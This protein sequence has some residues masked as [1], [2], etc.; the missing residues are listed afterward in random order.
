MALDYLD[1]DYSE[2][3]DGNG[4]W[5]AMASVADSRWAALLEEV[6]QVLH[7][8]S[9]DFRGRRAPLE[10]GGDWDYD[11]S[12]QDD[13]HGCALRIRWDRAGDAVQAEAP[14]P[15]G[16]GTVTLT[17]TGN[18]AFGDALRQAFDLE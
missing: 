10:D 3:E 16:Y 4:T 5:D 15:G 13:D 8:A 7:W 1:F 9:H 2:D 18:T 12:A 14:K 17:L 11:L 6:R